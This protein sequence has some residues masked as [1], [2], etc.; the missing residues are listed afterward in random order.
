MTLPPLTVVPAGAGSGKTYRIQQTL[1]EWVEQGLVHADRIVAV[2]FTEAAASELRERVRGRLLELGR[3]DDALRIDQAYISTIH[4]FGLRLL[5]EFAF[6]AG[7]SPHPRLLQEDEEK[8]LIRAAV[9]RTEQGDAVLDD[10][11]AFGYKFDFPTKTGPEDKFRQNILTAIER[12]RMLGRKPGGASLVQPALDHVSALYGGTGDGERMNAN[13]RSAV[14]ALLASHPNSLATLF[15]GNATAQREFRRDFVNLRRAQQPGRIESDWQLWQGLRTLR[16]SKRGSAT[17]DGYDELALAVMDAAA[18]LP[19]H[20]GPLRHARIH[21]ESLIASA[22]DVLD[23]FA[24]DK[25]DA[26]LL[27]YADM[28]TLA[29]DLLLDS[30]TAIAALGERTDCVVIDEFQDTNPIQFA[31]LWRLH[32]AGIPALVVGDL[33]QAIMGFQGTDARLFEQVAEQHRDAIEPLTKNWRSDARIMAFVNGIGARLFGDEYQPLTPQADSTTMQPLEVVHFPD[34]LGRSPTRPR[35]GHV[36]LRLRALLDDPTQQVI[37]RQTKQRRRLRAGDIAV[38]CPIHKYLEAYADV[39]R[40]LGLRVRLDEGGWIESRVVQ[41]VLHALQFTANPNDRHA[42]L[43][44]AT[45]ELG[46]LNLEQAI[47]ELIDNREIDDNV[48]ARLS[49][50]AADIEVLPLPEL[51]ARVIASLDLYGVIA[52]WPDGEQARANLLRLEAEAREFTGANRETLS[53]GGYYGSGIP[54]FLAW[55]T[56]RAEDENEQPDPRVVDEDAIELVTWH[57]SKG[58]EWPVVVVAGLDWDTDPR[59]PD[60]DV[61]YADF[62]DLDALLDGARIAWSPEFAAPETNEQFLDALRDEAFLSARR[63]LYVA[64]TR[65]REKLIIEWPDYLAQASN[66][67]LNYWALMTQDCDLRIGDDA[68]TIEDAEFPCAVTTGVGEPDI[69]EEQPDPDQIPVSRV[70]RIAI[71]PAETP[72]DLTPNSV[73]PSVHEGE[74]VEG[75]DSRIESYGPGLD[76]ELGLSPTARGEFL[77]RCFEVLGA[78]PDLAER[79]FASAGV[80]VDDVDKEKITTSV[81]EF[82]ALI[83]SQLEPIDV[84]RELPLLAGTESGS[85]LSGIADLVVET[86]AGLWIIDHKSDRV[87]DTEQRFAEHLPQLLAYRDALGGVGRMRSVVG[88]GINWIRRGELDL[89]SIV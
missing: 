4:S 70:G 60:F 9:A 88:V 64:L 24:A 41:L 75:S 8:A 3:H 17:P 82:E 29:C 18:E 34:R 50:I 12:L 21:V 53:A 7:M 66:P 79:Y 63:V 37:D 77:H 67:K 78:R 38:L 16:Q 80:P 15:A 58:R 86:P 27:D 85:V 52:R 69:D 10:L 81:A 43:Y 54:T 32:R 40:G 65:A 76:L 20:P 19:R 72:T 26:G 46:S 13:L 48:L 44:L 11:S 1:G 56:R 14:G 25:R 84:L 89:A 2:T 57:S 59:L 30:D 47:G 55:L 42:A 5:S 51:L 61:Q 87:T 73:S 45:T 23:S 22:E 36:G 35:A 33:K 74:T 31:L 83:H 71:E 39:F 6:E 62:N 49:A 68:I 28:V